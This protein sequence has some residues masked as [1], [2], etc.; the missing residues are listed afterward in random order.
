MCSPVSTDQRRQHAEA[1]SLSL[2]TGCFPCVDPSVHTEENRRASV[3]YNRK[4]MTKGHKQDTIRLYTMKII[5]I[6]RYCVAQ[7]EALSLLLVFSVPS[8]YRQH[9]EECGR[10]CFHRCLSVRAGVIPLIGPV[11]GVAL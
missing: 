1:L 9:L 6:H 4:I 5:I 8:C 2:V 10:L 11:Q 7:R 3:E